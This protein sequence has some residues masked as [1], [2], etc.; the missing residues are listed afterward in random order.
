VVEHHS[1]FYVY[2]AW[3][4]KWFLP[5]I[6]LWPDYFF[7]LS[8]FILTHVYGQSLQKTRP[9]DVYNYLVHRIARVY[10]LHVFVLGLLVLFECVRWLISQHTMVE[11]HHP[12]FSASTSLKYIPS[13]L[14]LIQAWGIHHVNSWNDPAW[15]VSA[16]FAC[17][18]IFPWI[19]RSGVTRSP[20]SAA[21]LVLLSCCGLL[22]IQLTRHTFDVTYDLGVP[23]A[24]FSFSLGCVMR[25]HLPELRKLVTRV[26]PTLVQLATLAAIVGLFAWK[27]AK[28]IYFIPLWVLLIVSLTFEDT[29]VARTLSW[30]PLVKLGDISYSIYM[31]HILILWIFLLVRDLFPDFVAPFLALPPPLVL[32][33]FLMV[34]TVVSLFTYEYVENP[35]R[36]YIRRRFGNKRTPP[37]MPVP[38]SAE[39]RA[40]Q[41]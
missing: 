13:N 9:G 34:T 2:P 25:Q 4:L 14:L 28:G 10:P 20:V 39:L 26:S 30:G 22:W 33:F 16:E 11:L 29:R 23:R 24:F 32:A 12:I 27:E 7:V 38:P 5:G 40:P 17:Y 41:T 15:S 18:L 1:W 8:G 31:I 37:A 21:L 19:V 35:G 36:R 6:Q 3:S